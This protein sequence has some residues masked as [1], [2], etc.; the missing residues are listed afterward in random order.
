MPAPKNFQITQVD[1]PIQDKHGLPVKGAYLTAVDITGLMGNIQ[2]RVIL[3][4]NQRIALNCLVAIEAKRATDGIEGFAA[5][6]DYD[7]WRESAKEHGLN[8]R[9]FKECIDALLKK[10]MVLENVGMYR[11]VPKQETNEAV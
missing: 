6:V 4:G 8:S 2:K 1:L 3:S 7:Q 9:R 10:S 5:M 11:T